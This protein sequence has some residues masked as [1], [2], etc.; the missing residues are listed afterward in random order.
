VRFF[1]GIFF[2]KYFVNHLEVF[3]G[4][5]NAIPERDPYPLAGVLLEL[6]PMALQPGEI[7]FFQFYSA[8]THARHP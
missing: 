7:L 8:L 2:A 5:D 1:A 6:L 4:G 3:S